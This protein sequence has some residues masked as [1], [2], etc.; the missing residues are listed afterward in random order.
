MSNLKTK[1][2]KSFYKSKCNTDAL[3]NLIVAGRELK[4][5]SQRELARRIGISNTTIN[6]L[7]RGN[8]Q[9]PGVEILINISEELEISINMLLKAAGY[10][11]LL[12]LLNNETSDV[13]L[14]K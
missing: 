14:E 4:N 8:I 11:K 6:D 5:V 3:K 7:E 10:G 1:E 13:E 2:T 12:T 9:K